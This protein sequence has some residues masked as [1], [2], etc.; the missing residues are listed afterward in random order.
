MIKSPG[1]SSLR[2]PR[3][4]VTSMT[5]KKSDTQWSGGSFSSLFSGGYVRRGK[6][7]GWGLRSGSARELLILLLPL[8]DLWQVTPPH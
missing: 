1:H 5:Q 6:S 4:L 8:R 7:L 3:G 2:T